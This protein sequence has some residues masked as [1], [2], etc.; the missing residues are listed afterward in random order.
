MK[1]GYILTPKWY[2]FWK[3]TKYVCLTCAT[4][5]KKEFIEALS[6]IHDT[7][8]CLWDFDSEDSPFLALLDAKRKRDEIKEKIKT[9]NPNYES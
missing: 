1:V 9:I 6:K 5:E 8:P 4:E 7:I 3:R 2:K